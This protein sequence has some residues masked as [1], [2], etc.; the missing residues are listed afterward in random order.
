[1]KNN[2][3]E[4]PQGIPECGSDALRFGLLAHTGKGKD[5][6]EAS[7]GTVVEDIRVGAETGKVKWDNPA[8]PEATLPIAQI[9][10]APTGRRSAS[11]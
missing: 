10:L 4:Y 11:R 1:M 9:A 5:I 6:K 2:E 8:Y 7:H 3:S